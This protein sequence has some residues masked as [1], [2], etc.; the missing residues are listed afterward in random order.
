MQP[1]PLVAK[2][3]NRLRKEEKQRDALKHQPITTPIPLD[4]FRNTYTSLQRNNNPNNSMP[5]TLAERR[6]TFRKGI[7]YAYYKKE[8]HIKEEC[9]KLLGYPH[10][11][12]LHNKYQPPSQRGTSTYKGGMTV[13]MVVGDTFTPIDTSSQ[14][15]TPLDQNKDGLTMTQ[16]K[17]A[18]KLVKHVGLLDT[19]PST[20]PLDPNAKLSM[21]NGDLLSDPSYYKTIVG[22]LLYLTITRP[23]L[24]FAAQALSQFLQQPRTIH[25][26]EFNVQVSTPVPMICDNASAK[27]LA[28]N[29]VHHART[30]HIEI[31]YHFV[32]DKIKAGQILPTYISTKS[33]WLIFSP[34]V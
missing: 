28:S 5:N 15:F 16:R 20:T 25:I 24:A 19:K 14:Q 29:P 12:Q 27:V 11:H 23:D 30:K 33:N 17:Y 7:F 6:S 3:Y 18:T 1:L 34:K 21:D 2:A 32:R 13:N 8:G 9:Y 10:G 31:D 26:K 22:K 4:T